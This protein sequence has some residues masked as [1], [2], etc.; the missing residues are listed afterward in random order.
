M[1]LEPAGKRIDQ[2]KTAIRR[3]DYLYY[4]RDAPEVSDAE[5]DRLYHELQDL[6]AQHPELCTPDSPT[7]RV[8]G[9]PLEGF[10][11]VEHAA[12]MLSLDSDQEEEALR[13]FD[14]RLKK[15]LGDRAAEYVLEPKLDGL[16]VELVYEGGRL[17]HASTRGDGVRGEGITENVRTIP[18]IPLVLRE[19]DRP[20]PE[21]L[22]IRGEVVIRVGAF[23]KLNERLISEGREPFANPRNAAAGSLRQLD[24]RVTASR[25]LDMYAYD[26]LAGSAIDAATQ[27]E[28]LGALRDWGLRVNDLSAL[29]TSVDDVLAYHADIEARRDD[30]DF[31]IDGIVI[32]LNNLADRDA[33]GMTSRHPRWAFAYK[34]PPRVETT[35]LER[36]MASVG[37]T[38]TVTPVALMRPVE[39]AGVTVSR[40][41]LHNWQELARK[42]VREGDLVRVQRAGDVIPQV[43]EHVPES[44]RERGPQYEPPAV[45]PSCGTGLLERGPFLV[46]PNNFACVAQLEGR[47]QHFGSRQGL[48]IEGLGEETARLLVRQGLVERL[49]DL[50][51]LSAEQ[52]LPLEGFAQTSADNLV[53]AI[54]AASDTE[55]R[56]FL[57]GLGIPEVGSAVARDLANHFGSIEAIRAADE[58]TLQAVDGVGPKMAERIV[59]FFAEPHNA[60]NVDGLLARM[61]VREVELPEAGDEADPPGVFAGKTV[62]FTG[63][64]ESMSRPHAKELVEALGGRVAGSVSNKTG[65][66]VAGQEA[67]SK[68]AKARDLGV[69][70]LTE[71]EFLRL[72][73]DATEEA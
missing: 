14:E 30:L 29:G 1:A 23:E 13:R 49:P 31:E 9:E 46:C 22:A 6:E 27:W 26:I 44:G 66:V 73:H 40:A 57:Y 36:I 62:V 5:Y 33:L 54:A 43:L 70:I 71:P 56:R 17:A 15:G 38:G 25:P 69:V 4:V 58:E 11:T 63:G 64:L 19:D 68:L 18:A 2:L 24:P 39:L 72:V 61:R 55:L 37:R 67:G 59:A 60:E 45:C 8:G 35:R 7:M 52:L 65:F 3:H 53:E 28:V 51:S 21:F 41:T 12:P 42:D 48:D 16:S 10:S 34:F 20:A 47:L 50:L 32:K